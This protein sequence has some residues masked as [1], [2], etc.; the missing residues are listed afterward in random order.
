ME[1][2]QVRQEALLPGSCDTLKNKHV[3]VFGIGGVGS[4]LCEALARAGVGAFTLVDGDTVAESN[5]NRQLIADTKSIGKYK[6]EVMKE[7][8]SL[9]NPKAKVECI[10]RF[11]QAEQLSQVFDFK[12]DYVA[13]AIDTVSVKLELAKFCQDN[14]IFLLSAMGTGNKIHPELFEIADIYATSVCPLCRAMRSKLKAMGVKSLKVVYSRE[15]PISAVMQKTDGRY[16]PASISFTPPVAGMIMA[17][18]IIRNLLG[19]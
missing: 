7:R 3:T 15:E 9:I 1:S 18:E 19:I 12:T 17:G 10:N 5:I 6:A 16:P 11:I 2:W 13:D 14:N 8:I 4:Y